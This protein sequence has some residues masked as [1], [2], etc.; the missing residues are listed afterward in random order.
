METEELNTDTEREQ[1]KDEYAFQRTDLDI[2]GD[3]KLYCYE[4]PKESS[5]SNG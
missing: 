3:R 2:S 1:P 5:R 4:F